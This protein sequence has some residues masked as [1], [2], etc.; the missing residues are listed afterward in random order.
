[1]FWWVPSGHDSPRAL[2]VAQVK[3]DSKELGEL[4]MQHPSYAKQQE[5]HTQLLDLLDHMK[6]HDAKHS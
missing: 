4:V 2:F 6:T 5:I 1:M 3:S